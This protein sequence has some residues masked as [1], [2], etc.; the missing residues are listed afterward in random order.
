MTKLTLSVERSEADVF[1]SVLTVSITALAIVLVATIASIFIYRDNLKKK[2]KELTDKFSEELLESAS[3]VAQDLMNSK[4]EIRAASVSDYYTTMICL[5]G[6]FYT[7]PTFQL[8]MGY[9]KRFRTTG[10]HFC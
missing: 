8:V 4:T 9:Q 3:M 10:I 7:L 2:F 5:M 6:V 1:Y